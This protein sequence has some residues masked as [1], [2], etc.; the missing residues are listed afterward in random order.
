MPGLLCPSHHNDPPS[1]DIST[2]GGSGDG[3]WKRR[4]IVQ[5]RFCT[6][7]YFVFRIHKIAINPELAGTNNTAGTAAVLVRVRSDRRGHLLIVAT[8]TRRGRENFCLH[9][10]VST[11]SLLTEQHFYL[12][13]AKIATSPCQGQRTFRRGLEQKARSSSTSSTLKRIGIG[14]GRLMITRSGFLVLRW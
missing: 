8:A 3:D 1:E 4:G 7:T 11:T 12:F 5:M 13:F 14:S 2:A 10:F 6:D 9:L